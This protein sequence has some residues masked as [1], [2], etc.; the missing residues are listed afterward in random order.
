MI[1]S[2]V[3]ENTVI[4]QGLQHLLKSSEEFE[5]ITTYSRCEELLEGKKVLKPDIIVLGFIAR[6]SDNLI[7]LRKVKNH[8]PNSIVLVALVYE[9][10]EIIFNSMQ[11]G[12]SGYILKNCT[13]KKIFDTIKDITEKKAFMSVQM[14]KH[15]IEHLERKRDRKTGKFMN[16]TSTEISLLKYLS[17]GNNLPALSVLTNHSTEQIKSDFFSIYRKIR[18]L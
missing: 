16:L 14:A 4:R 11:A 12:A 5:I 7:S 10:D 13:S 8:F 3:E 17:E 6:S 1:I 15:I 18:T 2:I 9:D